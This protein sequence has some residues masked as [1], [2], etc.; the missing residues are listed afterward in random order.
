MDGRYSRISS[1]SKLATSSLTITR[2]SAQLWVFASKED[3]MLRIHTQ[4]VARAVARD[5]M[6][7]PSNTY[8]YGP[9]R[10]L[11]PRFDYSSDHIVIAFN[12][13]WMHIGRYMQFAY[14]AKADW[15]R[16]LVAAMGRQE[17]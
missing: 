16:D 17:L 11:R 6:V 7:I 14:N 9:R 1:R 2:Q 3:K 10:A 13:L 5:N 15:Y 8:N 4:P 12:E